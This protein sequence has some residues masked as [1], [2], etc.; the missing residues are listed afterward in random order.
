MRILIAYFRGK[1]SVAPDPAV[2]RVGEHIQFEFM[3]SD[4]KTRQNHEK[5]RQLRWTVEFRE[6]LPIIGKEPM[7]K[8]KTIDK[9]GRGRRR[10]RINVGKADQPGDYKYAISI[11]VTRMDEEPEEEQVDPIIMILP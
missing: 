7:K 10:K 9:K 2:L 8:V 4:E 6:L 5:V 3:L 1:I 11:E